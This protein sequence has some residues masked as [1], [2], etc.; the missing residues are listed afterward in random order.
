MLLTTLATAE[1]VQ[2]IFLIYGLA[3][4]HRSW[5]NVWAWVPS[6]SSALIT[7]LLRLLSIASRSL[8][9]FPVVL[10]ALLPLAGACPY[11]AACLVCVKVFLLII[12][13]YVSKSCFPSLFSSVHIIEWTYQP[14]YLWIYSSLSLKVYP[15]D[16]SMYFRYLFMFEYICSPLLEPYFQLSLCLFS[17]P[18]LRKLSTYTWHF[19]I[20]HDLDC[21]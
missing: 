15:S 11:S 6:S 14:T 18:V 8:G 19:F 9:K 7:I 20:S 1:Y 21:R 5:A 12:S 10:K 4:I 13:L 16:Y 17:R 3:N 2:K